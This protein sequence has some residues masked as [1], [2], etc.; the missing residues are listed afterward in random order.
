MTPPSRPPP[1]FFVGKTW[2][3]KAKQKNK[4]LKMK[5]VWGVL[6]AKNEKINNKIRQISIFGSH[7]YKRLVKDLYFIYG[8]S[9]FG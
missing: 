5:Q 3:K 2:R 4:I 6:I 8:L 7:E 9:G 1:P